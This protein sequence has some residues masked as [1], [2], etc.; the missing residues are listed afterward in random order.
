MIIRNKEL[1]KYLKDKESKGFAFIHSVGFE[2]KR[3][4]PTAFGFFKDGQDAD[5]YYDYY[6]FSLNEKNKTI[7]FVAYPDGWKK[8]IN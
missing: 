4:R 3:I 1:R 6:D 2:E 8:N 5:K 7:T